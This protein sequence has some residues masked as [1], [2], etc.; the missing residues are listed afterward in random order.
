M[1]VDYDTDPLPVRA[2]ATL[3]E[4][5]S[6]TGQETHGIEVD[7]DIFEELRAPSTPD[8]SKPGTPYEAVDLNFRLKR[9]GRAV[10]AGIRLPNVNE[11]FT[12]RAPDLGAYEL[13]QPLP[14]YGPRQVTKPPF[15]R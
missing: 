6:E 2:F 14:I 12:G 5:A 11:A 9:G 3:G 1:L 15:Y 4:L 8:S 10:D 13:D 7:Y